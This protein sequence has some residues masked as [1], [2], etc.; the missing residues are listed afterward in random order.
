MPAGE[1]V[2]E[3]TVTT[4]RLDDV[5]PVG[6]EPA[7]IKIDVE[8]AELLVLRGAVDTVARHKPMVIF[9]HGVGGFERYGAAPG[10]LHDLLVTDCGLRIFDLAGEGPTR[11]P[12][13]RTCSPSRSGTSSRAEHMRGAQPIHV[14]LNLVFLVPGE[15]GGMEIYARELIPRLAA[16][17][18]PA[19]DR[20]RQPRGRRGEADLAAVEQEVR[21]RCARAAGVEWVRGE[22]QH[23]PRLAAR[24][25]ADLVHTSPRTAPLRGRVPRVT[26]IHDLNYAKSCP[27]AHFGVRGLGMRVLVPA[28]ARRSR[29]IIVDAASTR[30]DLVADLGA[31]PEQD[32]R[33]PAR[34]VASRRRADARRRGCARGSGSATRPV[35]LSVSAKR[36][37]KNLERLLRRRR[38][39]PA[40]SG[41]RCS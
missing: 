37:H 35:V 2:R 27:D 32:R 22:Q 31:P 25:G 4:E 11:A 15:T 29:R 5:L 26:T 1:E 38:G 8:G 6:F 34:R 33:R 21:S 19:A 12:G 16:L 41:A 13:S 28:A 30:D 18:G 7:L 10:D 23:V 36:P 3:I 14:A 24:A 20:A 40:R 9:E 39:D 17:R